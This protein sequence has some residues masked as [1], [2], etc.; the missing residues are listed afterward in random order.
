MDAMDV[1]LREGW[2]GDSS[3][4]YAVGLVAGAFGVR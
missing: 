3:G 4:G 2:S 1:T